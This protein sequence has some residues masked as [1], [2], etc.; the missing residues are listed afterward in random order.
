M[1]KINKDWRKKLTCL[2]GLIVASVVNMLVEGNTLLYYGITLG[3]WILGAN[4]KDDGKFEVRLWYGAW[5][6]D[7]ILKLKYN[8]DI[9]YMILGIYFII[10]IIAY[11]I[12]DSSKYKW[13][14]IVG[15][16]LIFTLV[17]SMDFYMTKDD[18]I[19]DKQLER[20]I[21]NKIGVQDRALTVSD[22]EKVKNLD[23]DYKRI[24]NLEGIE[25]LKN[26]E[27]LDIYCGDIR[28]LEVLSSL[29]SLKKLYL[30]GVE[31][32]SKLNKFN[33]VEKLY[34]RLYSDNIEGIEKVTNLKGLE[35]RHVDDVNLKLLESMKNLEKLSI[36]YSDI[37]DTSFVKNL[38]NLKE[39]ELDEN[40]IKDI[41]ALKNL[42]NLEKLDIGYNDIEDISPIKNLVSLEEL[43]LSGNKFKDLSPL[44]NLK[45]LQILSI[46][47]NE[48]LIQGLEEFKLENIDALNSLVYLKELN[49][50]KSGIQ[51]LSDIK[52]LKSLEVLDLGSNYI[53]NI[54][55]IEQ[56]TNLKKLYL[57]K[58]NILDLKYIEGM[59]KLEELYLNEN[60]IKD[61]SYIKNLTNLK[62]LGL[63]HNHIED[64]SGLKKLSNLK[65]VDL[66]YNDVVN[67]EPIK[68]LKKIK[69]LRIGKNRIKD[70]TPIEDWVDVREFKYIQK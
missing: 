65:D 55:Y 21:K 6:I 8:Y 59:T 4:I 23:T 7:I 61:I 20:V 3:V 41:T 35:I 38:T 45:K 42:K 40:K 63:E 64:I 27:V 15:T 44:E 14:Q 68:N 5:I 66:S 29:G 10:C 57:S 50:S 30:S 48:M 31:D 54:E 34:V 9:T 25:Y 58:N 37:E 1:G 24:H 69:S 49:A 16:I 46:S 28:N 60:N 32:I 19:K 53:E 12:K 11:I 62:E 13:Q 2:L 56:L 52:N 22:L 67:I 17:F 70:F 18:L 47:S 43:R 26:L 33:H 39:L 36:S 51:D